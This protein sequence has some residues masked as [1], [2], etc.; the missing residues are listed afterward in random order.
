MA[1]R[2]YKPLDPEKSDE[3]CRLIGKDDIVRKRLSKR[4]K[5]RYRTANDIEND[6]NVA[7]DKNGQLKILDLGCFDEAW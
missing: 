2:Y 5:K 6:G 7:R 1:M 4:I 3:E